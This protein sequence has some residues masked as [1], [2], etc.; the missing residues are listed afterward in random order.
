MDQFTV[1][2]SRKFKEAHDAFRGKRIMDPST[3]E[4][5]ESIKRTNNTRFPINLQGSFSF[6][7]VCICNI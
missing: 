4:W 2:L 5:V 6:Y 3:E 1:L 7:V